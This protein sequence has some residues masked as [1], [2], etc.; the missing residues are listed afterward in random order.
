MLIIE[1]RNSCLKKYLNI[2]YKYENYVLTMGYGGNYN[3]TTI[4]EIKDLEDEY[5]K[6]LQDLKVYGRIRRPERYT[7]LNM[8]IS[9]LEVLIKNEITTKIK[10]NRE[11]YR[12]YW[13]IMLIKAKDGKW[14]SEIID[15]GNLNKPAYPIETEI[16]KFF[17]YQSYYPIS[18]IVD[19]FSCVEDF[20]KKE[21]SLPDILQ[22]NLE[23]F[24]DARNN[25]THDL[26]D[27]DMDLADDVRN[28]L[29]SFIENIKQII[30][31]SLEYGQKMEKKSITK[32]DKRISDA[33]RKYLDKIME[34][35]LNLNGKKFNKEFVTT[36]KNIRKSL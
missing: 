33:Q 36:L 1:S 7:F 2:F 23:L 31:R 14:T 13:P 16:P 29:P 9:L 35:T 18:I 25:S 27:L 28:Q 32:E 30:S 12:K 3:D 21:I 34:P 17:S 11:F 24:F 8:T 20:M 15:S 10:E 19:S 4:I 5:V 22:K 6:F 26:E